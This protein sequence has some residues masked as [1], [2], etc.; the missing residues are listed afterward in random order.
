MSVNFRM[1]AAGKNAELYIYDFVGEWLGGISPKQVADVLKDA[2]RVETINVRINSPGGDVFDGITI[3]NLLKQ[4]PARIVVDID[5]LAA[6]IAS[7]IA[8]S[9]DDV[10]M[11]A[12]AM[13]MIHN[14]IGGQFGSAEDMRKK[15]DLMDKTKG[16]MVETYAARTG[17]DHAKLSDMMDAETWM[18]AAEAVDHGFVDSVTEQLQ[19]AACHDLSRFTNAPKLP[20]GPRANPFR[21]RLAANA[22]RVRKVCGVVPQ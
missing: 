12:N 6:S 13:F 10:R 20:Q 19:M 14:P 21:A 2:G 16:Q 8:M 15:A 4:H 3:G 17:I 11:A 5:G 18:T 7:I 22:A 9:G 1:R